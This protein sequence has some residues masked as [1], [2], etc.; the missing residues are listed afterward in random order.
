MASVGQAMVID[1]VD[2]S[3]VPIGQIQRA[4]VFRKHANFRVSHVF[5]FNSEGELL[6][7][8]LAL[9][10]DRNPGYWGSFAAAYL[11]SHEDYWAA[12]ARRMNEELGVAGAELDFVNKTTMQDYGC[13]KFISLFITKQEG[14]FRYDH[15]HIDRVEFRPL[16]EINQMIASDD[17]RF[18]PTFLHVLE[19][20]YRT[21]RTR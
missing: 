5:V 13:L 7:Q 8:R 9:N 4:E 12:A 14:P 3:D 17:R 16:S 15:Q 18:T 2:Q 6:I 20:F 11:F 1:T 21:A 19:S 10:R